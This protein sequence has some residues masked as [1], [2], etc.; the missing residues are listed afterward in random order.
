MNMTPQTRLR[1]GLVLCC[2]A[3]TVFLFSCSRDIAPEVGPVTPASG[4]GRTQV[5]RFEASHP[6]GAQAVADMQVFFAEALSDDVPACL[7]DIS[8]SGKTLAVRTNNSSKTAWRVGIAIGSPG[9]AAADN[10]SVDASRVKVERNGNQVVATVPL[11]FI[12]AINGDLSVWMIAS[13]PTQHSGWQK[14]GTWTVE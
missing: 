12:G 4:H 14:R 3:L 7:I 13:G 5:F 1:S 9:T 11:A 8:N 6:D 2:S 10:C